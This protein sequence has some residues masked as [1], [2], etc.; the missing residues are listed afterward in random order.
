MHEQSRL[1]AEWTEPSPRPDRPTR[2]HGGDEGRRE[3]DPGCRSG[4]P[5]GFAADDRCHDAHRDGPSGRRGGPDKNEAPLGSHALSAGHGDARRRQHPH[6]LRGALQRHGRQHEW[7][8]RPSTPTGRT[9]DLRHRRRL[10]GLY[11]RH[12]GRRRVL[13]VR[14]VSASGLRPHGHASPGDG[15]TISVL[16]NPMTTPADLIVGG[17]A[18]APTRLAKGSDSPVLTVDPTT[19]LLVWATPS[20]GFSDPM[21][22]RGDTIIRNASNVTARLARGPA[23]TVLRS[24]G[25]DLSYGAVA[26][27]ELSGVLATQHHSNANDPTS[28]QAAALAGTSGTPGSGNKYVTDGDSR[29]SDTR[30]PTAHATSHKSR[31]SDFIKLNEV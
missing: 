28:G 4:R 27:S 15:G 21:T 7:N 5:L 6:P 2:R 25:T 31:G 18:G 30:T 19:H 8:R 17:T 1:G 29:N 3:H 26:H 11:P 14:A 20:G 12:G 9:L 10:Q 24:D 23:A 13:R 16:T 22:T